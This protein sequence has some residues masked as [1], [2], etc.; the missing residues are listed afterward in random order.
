[1]IVSDGDTPPMA[2]PV[3]SFRLSLLDAAADYIEGGMIDAAARSLES[4]SGRSSDDD[5][6]DWLE[7][8]RAGADADVVAAELRAEVAR[9]RR[10]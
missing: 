7:R 8:I 10:E 3:P 6:A 5:V 9:L 2:A 4:L 1:M